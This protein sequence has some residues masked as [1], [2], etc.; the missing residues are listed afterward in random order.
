MAN[1]GG[2]KRLQ[3]ADSEFRDDLDPKRRRTLPQRDCRSRRSVNYDLSSENCYRED[4]DDD[5][6]QDVDL[7]GPDRISRILEITNADDF[8]KIFEKAKRCDVEVKRANIALQEKDEMEGRVRD[9]EAAMK[10]LR[11]T[12]GSKKEIGEGQEM[13]GLQSTGP[14]YNGIES[15]WRILHSNARQLFSIKTWQDDGLQALFEKLL[16]ASQGQN[17]EKGIR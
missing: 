10:E 14:G 9:M 1:D 6:L 7:R 16:E 4:A 17:Q 8:A 5:E 11:E 12:I 13:S 2:T 15:A 3:E